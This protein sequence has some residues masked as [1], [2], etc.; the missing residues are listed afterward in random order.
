MK[1]ICVISTGIIL[2]GSLGT[3]LYNRYKNKSTKPTET[4]TETQTEILT[5]TEE[6]KCNVDKSDS[7]SVSDCEA[8]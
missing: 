4:S 5:D 2:L 3:I 1:P 6:I 8:D 7:E